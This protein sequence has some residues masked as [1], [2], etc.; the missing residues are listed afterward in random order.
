VANPKAWLPYFGETS[1]KRAAFV[2]AGLVASLAFHFAIPYT[3]ML[4]RVEAVSDSPVIVDLIAPPIPLPPADELDP[5]LDE[6]DVDA[7]DIEDEPVQEP[8]EDDSEPV[9]VPPDA[10]P[11][12]APEEAADVAPSDAP[13][14]DEPAEVAADAPAMTEKTDAEIQAERDERRRKRLEER[15]RRFEERRKKRKGSGG[16]RGGAPDSGEW[17]TGTPDS[18]YACTATERGEELRVHKERPLHEWVSIVPT[19]LSGFRTRPDI[20]DYLD[21][22]SQ[23]VQRE[24]RS[25]KRLGFGEVAL[26]SEVLQIELDEPK[27]VRIAV[28]RLDARCLVGFKYTAQLF[29]M[30]LLRAPIRII[31]GTKSSAHLVD[32]V[33][34]KDVSFEMR[35]VDGSVLPFSK[36]RLK[37]GKAIAQNIDDHYA[38]ARF[39][40]Q[41]ADALGISFTSRASPSSKPVGTHKP[42]LA[43][44]KS[45]KKGTD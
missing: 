21:E 1:S 41:I 3:S 8:E 29:P 34:F 9:P 25:L 39:A 15:R 43:S 28:G 26:D 45:K 27:G 33:M 11:P 2:G 24:K 13:A 18:V 44:G 17:K 40:K 32:F 19:V 37:N 23:I 5:S 20:G 16:R 38:A 42:T 35:S 10:P 22:A 4:H 36:G 31:E 14:V 12:D 6:E 30:T 7:P